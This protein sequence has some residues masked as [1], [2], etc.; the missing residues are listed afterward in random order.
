MSNEKMKPFTGPPLADPG[1]EVGGRKATFVLIVCSALYMVNYMDRQVLSV[2]LEPMKHDLGLSDAQAGLLQ[3]GFLISMGLF[4]IP[5]S[6]LVDRWSRSKAIS[7]MA[8]FW[9]A[10]TFVTGLGKSF[11]GVFIP[12]VLTGTGEAAFSSGAIALISA[13]YPEQDRSK[14]LAVYNLFLLFGVAAGM[15]LGGHLSAHHGGWR[16]PFFVFAVPGV[17]LG[18]FA[19]FMQDYKNPSGADIPA[20]EPSGADALARKLSGADTPA[21]KLSTCSPKYGNIF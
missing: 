17:I 9:S 8:V 7:L 14:K 21:R 20:R 12:R 13:S 2:V 10:A 18:V 19:W 4:A 3:T 16:T 1:F 5:L 11:L 15:I 6:Y